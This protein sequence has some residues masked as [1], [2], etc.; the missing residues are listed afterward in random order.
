MNCRLLFRL[1]QPT[2]SI[3]MST[4]KWLKLNDTVELNDGSQGTVEQ[5]DDRGEAYGQLPVCMLNHPQYKPQVLL[6]Q[7]WVSTSR[8]ACINGR[9]I[10]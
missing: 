7:G 1:N 10:Q 2:M 9:P 8:V 6:E 3:R 4:P 5:I